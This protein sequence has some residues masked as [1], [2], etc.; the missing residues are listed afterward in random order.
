MK[1][2]IFLV[3]LFA[4]LCTQPASADWRW[5]KPQLKKQTISYSCDTL[6]CIE[7]AFAKEKKRYKKRVD[8]YNARRLKEWKHWTSIYIPQCTWY[9]ESGTSAEYSPVRY[10][11]SNSTG[12]GAYGKFQ[13]MPGTYHNRAKYHDWSALDQEIASRREYWVNGT[14]P[15]ANCQ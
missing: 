3:L 1:R 14:Q 4:L 13:M 12:S 5:A 8:R 9:G 6:E 2:L 10:T 7:K 15:W 11:M